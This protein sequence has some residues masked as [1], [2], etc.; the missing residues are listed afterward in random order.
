MKNITVITRGTVAMDT[1]IDTRE[2]RA[3]HMRKKFGTNF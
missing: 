3:L 2:P 1:V